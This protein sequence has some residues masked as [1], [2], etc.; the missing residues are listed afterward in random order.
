[1]LWSGTLVAEAVIYSGGRLLLGA[2]CPI[3]RYRAE[4]ML[5]AMVRW[6]KIIESLRVGKTG[7]AQ[8]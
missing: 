1:V 4:L 6:G 5:R 7:N 2:L 3:R 8:E